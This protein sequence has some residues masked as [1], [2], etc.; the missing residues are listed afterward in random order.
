M[1]ACY[2]LQWQALQSQQWCSCS[3]AFAHALPPA[4]NVLPLCRQSKLTAHN[5]LPCLPIIE[6]GKRRLRF[7]CRGHT[8]VANEIKAE[9]PREDILSWIKVL[10]KGSLPFSLLSTRNRNV[11]PMGTTAVPQLC[12]CKNDQW[13]VIKDL[14]LRRMGGNKGLVLRSLCIVMYVVCCTI[15][16]GTIVIDCDMVKLWPWFSLWSSLRREWREWQ[17]ALNSVNCAFSQIP[18]ATKLF[19]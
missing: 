9:V 8:V 15:L 14:M 6:I 3:P 17:K 12:G 16:G 7:P 13:S 18:L 4:W 10:T 19:P 5:L 11:K 1:S 2:A